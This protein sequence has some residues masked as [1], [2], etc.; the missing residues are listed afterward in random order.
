MQHLD[1]A[2]IHAWL[3]GALSPDQAA[4][5]EAHAA[6]CAACAAGVAE[7]RGFV[8]AS[9]RITSALDDVPR[10]VIVAPRTRPHISRP[11]LQAAAVLVVVAAGGL[12]VIRNRPMSETGH[13]TVVHHREKGVSVGEAPQSA[14]SSAQQT[15]AP[16]PAAIPAL[17][18]KV[19]TVR[20]PT[21][22]TTVNIALSHDVDQLQTVVTTGV[23]TAA[24][25]PLKVVKVERVASGTQTTYE[26]TPERS[27]TLTEPDSIAARATGGGIAR[28]RVMASGAVA[29][30]R[31]LARASSTTPLAS[32]PVSSEQAVNT[33]QW[34]EESTGKTLVLSGPFSV[35][36][37][38]SIKARI[39]DL[40][41]HK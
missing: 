33:I 16:P 37:L 19:P 34:T 18:A 39:E 26:I 8:A 4:R 29:F 11:L 10:G 32:A 25:A 24:S 3:D 38:E 15:S 6:E 31:R 36:E 7:A 23:A 14:L 30:E 22:D 27:V 28:G 5:A 35:S 41:A 40:R 9:S 1:E 20:P 13:A 12:L 2:T 21:H 17:T